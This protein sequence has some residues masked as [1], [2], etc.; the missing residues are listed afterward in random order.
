MVIA[1]ELVKK[2]MEQRIMDLFSPDLS[3]YWLNP[4]EYDAGHE[5]AHDHADTARADQEAA[6]CEL[7]ERVQA[8]RCVV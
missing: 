7:S 8:A 1:L 3:Q 4:V 2:A 5:S 6:W